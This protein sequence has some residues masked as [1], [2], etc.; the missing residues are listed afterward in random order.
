M[1]LPLGHVCFFGHV[2][3]PQSQTQIAQLQQSVLLCLCVIWD[4]PD[5]NFPVTIPTSTCMRCQCSVCGFV[6]WRGSITICV[7]NISSTFLTVDIFYVVSLNNT[8]RYAALLYALI[9]VCRSV[10]H[11]TG[12]VCINA[13][14]CKWHSSWDECFEWECCLR[15]SLF[16]LSK[17]QIIKIDL[18]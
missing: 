5:L 7:E 10:G 12:G 16:V 9:A 4:V 18:F 15:C 11:P 1:N 13:V 6:A 17:M 2:I 8:K 3:S 14:I